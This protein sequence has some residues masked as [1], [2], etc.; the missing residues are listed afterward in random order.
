MSKLSIA[1]TVMAGITLFVGIYWLFIYYRRRASREDLTFALTCL[2][3]GVYD[4]HCI[5]LYSVTDPVHGM[6]WQRG[7][8]ASAALIGITFTF[9]VSDCEYIV[10]VR[11]AKYLELASIQSDL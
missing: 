7:Q 2:A 10:T 9:F 5:G 8:L 4:L 6:F 3:V 11:F 1:P